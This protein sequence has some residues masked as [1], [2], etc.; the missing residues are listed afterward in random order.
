M[1]TLVYVHIFQC[2]FLYLS[3]HIENYEFTLYSQFQSPTTW[4]IIEFSF[5]VFITPFTG[6][7]KL[8]CIIILRYLLIW[9]IPSILPIF[10]CHCHPFCVL[11]PLH[12][13]LL[14]LLVPGCLLILHRRP[15]SSVGVHHA[16]PHPLGNAFPFTSSGGAI[17][18]WLHLF[19]L[20]LPCGWP[21]ILCDPVWTLASIPRWSL[22]RFS[23]LVLFR[24]WYSS[25][26]SYLWRHLRLSS[27]P[28]HPPSPN[29]WIPTFLY[30]MDLGIN[31]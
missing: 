27:G 12:F 10:C 16:G 11:M 14:G 1:Y 9:P 6:N 2:L 3:V 8:A 30:L 21:S 25:W 31:Y 24:F 5:C 29:V 19:S 7:R 22:C 15:S 17:N 28:T 23:L 26:G 20:P 18:S 13:A 4:V